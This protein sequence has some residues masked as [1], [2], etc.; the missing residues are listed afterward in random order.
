MSEQAYEAVITAECDEPLEYVFRN[1]PKQVHI[2]K[3]SSVDGRLLPGA[4]LEVTN[5]AGEIVAAGETDDKGE[6]TFPLPQPGVYTVREKK[7]PAGFVLTDEAVTFTVSAEGEITGTTQ[8]VNT[9]TRVVI[10]KVDK[11]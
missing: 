2:T 11:W 6:L 7:A 5:A 8:I 10:T 1:A 9:P 4:A 3:V